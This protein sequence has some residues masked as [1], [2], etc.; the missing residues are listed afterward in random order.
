[1]VKRELIRFAICA[2]VGLIIGIILTIA[3]KV[4]YFSLIGPFYGVGTFYGIKLILTMLGGIGKAA[5]TS[6]FTAIAGGHFVGFLFVLL[7]MIVFIA[8]V[9][10]FGWIIGLFVAGKALFDASRT[11][12]DIRGYSRKQHEP[13]WDN[14]NVYPKDNK[15]LK[16]NTAPSADDPDLFW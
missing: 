5:G 3:Q 7:L 2:A 14:D 6:V 12:S 10:F 8:L 11:D 15:P 9:L 16:G 4:W 1:M 13:D